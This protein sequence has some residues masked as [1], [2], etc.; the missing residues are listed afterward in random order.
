MDLVE[1]LQQLSQDFTGTT[2]QTERATECKAETEADTSSVRTSKE[3]KKV[4]KTELA[5]KVSKLKEPAAKKSTKTPAAKNP[6]VAE[7][8]EDPKET[9]KDVPPKKVGEFKDIARKSKNNEYWV[10]TEKQS[11]GGL[12]P[13]TLHVLI[14]H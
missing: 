1:K 11:D 12:G 7:K 2:N 9:K 3:A 6:A 14:Y 4:E 5:K 10:L 8:K 13:K